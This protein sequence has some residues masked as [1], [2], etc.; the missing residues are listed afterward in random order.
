MN[1]NVAANTRDAVIGKLKTKVKTKH[2]MLVDYS[3]QPEF[4]NALAIGQKY[5]SFYA[6]SFNIE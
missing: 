1:N 2:C 6:P 4:F 5:L 3:C